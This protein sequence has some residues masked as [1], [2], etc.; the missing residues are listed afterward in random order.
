M[1]P[2]YKKLS[3]DARK[4]EKEAMKYLGNSLLKNFSGWIVGTSVS[5]L[6]FLRNF[7]GEQN[8]LLNNFW[9]EDGLFTLCYEKAS[10]AAC[11]L[12]SYSGYLVI[13]PRLISF[14]VSLFPLDLWALINNVLYLFI[15]FLLAYFIFTILHQMYSS[16][17]SALITISPFI[18]AISSDQILGVHS[19]LYLIVSAYLIMI[20][21]T[22]LWIRDSSPVQKYLLSFLIFLHSL[23]TPIGLIILLI[24]LFR[25]TKNLNILNGFKST[26]LSSLFGCSIQ[27]YSIFVASEDRDSLTDPILVLKNS[28]NYFV[29]SVIS[30][31]Y[32]P[33]D[34][35]LEDPIFLQQGF[36]D[37]MYGNPI[38]LI[39]IG[40][41]L[42]ITPL[43][44]RRD[45]FFHLQVICYS[46]WA[47]LFILIISSYSYGSPY[48][49]IVLVS[50]IN[51]WIMVNLIEVIQNNFVKFISISFL[52]FPLLFN[53]ITNFPVSGYRTSGPEWSKEIDS[54]FS[55]CLEPN[56][57]NLYVPITF[58][59]N[60]PTINPHTHGLYEPTT[61][62]ISC[63]QLLKSF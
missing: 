29:K 16:F 59:P 39:S 28:F 46:S 13:Y 55:F 14:L 11:A 41:L 36:E 23:T 12:D 4:I 22:D 37:F 51:I 10:F 45:K 25:I 9:A 30:I 57:T 44:L 58:Y 2:L 61:N 20:V 35:R 1:L 54:Q 38:I 19:S 7:T 63:K 60:W 43:L 6:I 33:R 26:V 48:R 34:S 52:I 17:N 8:Y 27:I 24:M 42:F 40:F 15:V 21:S 18:L 62:L 47:N 5:V 56:N 49:F 50:V 3:W 32:Y 53:L 31:F